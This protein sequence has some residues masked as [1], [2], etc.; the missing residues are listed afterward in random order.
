MS[1]PAEFAPLL[2]MASA[3]MSA[4]MVV[5]VVIGVTAVPGGP[6]RA[7][8]RPLMAV[9]LAAG[10]WL[11]L[12]AGAAAEAAPVERTRPTAVESMAKIPVDDAR[13]TVRC[14]QYGRLV[15]EASNVQLVRDAGGDGNGAAADGPPTAAPAKGQRRVRVLDLR[16]GLCIID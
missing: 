5:R 12:G 8:V 7:L 10:F 1:A 11:A 16:Q 2:V 15:Y 9:M 3:A 14:W 13:P 6:V 4:A